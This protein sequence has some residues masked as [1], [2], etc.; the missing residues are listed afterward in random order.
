MLGLLALLFLLA[1]A[2]CACLVELNQVDRNEGRSKSDSLEWRLINVNGSISI[3]SATAGRSVHRDL[4]TAGIIP[5]P[6]VG[7]NEG[8]TRWVAEEP[9]WTYSTSLAHLEPLNGAQRTLLHF[10]WID[11]RASVI[12]SDSLGSSITVLEANNAHRRW[13]EDITAHLRIGQGPFT[14][15]IQLHSPITFAAQESKHEPP[16]PTQN[17]I[18]AAPA[19]QQYAYPH[20]N[21]IRMASHDFGW[22][23]GP[24]FADSGFGR[25]VLVQFGPCGEDAL[26]LQPISSDV[27]IVKSDD[28]LLIDTA[29]DV[30]RIGGHWRVNASLS[31][32][33]A[34]TDNIYDSEVHVTVEGT[35][36]RCNARLANDIKPG[37]NDDG[38]LWAICDI[39]TAAPTSRDLEWKV[40]LGFRSI[41][42]DQ[43]VYTADEVKKDGITP[44]SAFAFYINDHPIPLPIL[45]SNLIPFSTFTLSDR[46]EAE[47]IDYTMN[48]LIASEQN[49][50][51]I[52]GGGHYGSDRLYAKADELG[53]LIWSEFAFACSLYPTYPAFLKNVKVEAEEQV[54]RVS[55]YAS[56][57]LWAGNNEGELDMLPVY[58]TYANGSVYKQQ[59]EQLFNDLLRRVVR[60]HHPV[61]AYIASSTTTGGTYLEGSNY[62]FLP[63][64]R[65]FPPGE[66]HGDGE[67][68]NYNASQALDTS[69]YPRSRFVNEFG[70]HSM[71]DIRA[72]D[73]IVTRPED[74]DFNSTIVRSRSKH[75]PPGNL[76]YPW[77]ADDGQAQMTEGVAA[78]FPIPR[79]RS[80]HQRDTR[81]PSSSSG[82]VG[83]LGDRALLAQ[84]AYSTQCYQALYIGNQI[85]FYRL[86]T[87]GPER[88]TGSL[89]WQLNSIW[90]AATDWASLEVDG[91]WKILHYMVARMHDQVIAYVHHDSARRLI[92][93]HAI[94]R[95]WVQAAGHANVT[96]YDWNGH[97]IERQSHSFRINATASKKIAAFDLSVSS[98]RSKY[99]AKWLHVQL[100]ASLEGSKETF[101]NEQFFTPSSLGRVP[102][103][104]AKLILRAPRDDT[105]A[106]RSPSDTTQHPFTTRRSTEALEV[107]IANEGPGVAAWVVLT[108]S[109]R[110]KGWFVDAR[111]RGKP[112]NGFWLRPGENRSLRFQCHGGP[113][114]A[115]ASV[116]RDVSVTSMWDNIEARA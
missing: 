73:K 39:P 108:H 21:F 28:L 34:L 77:P 51:R 58:R 31:L 92:Q 89:Y 69:T 50:I 33:S 106:W 19:S 84:W 60:S 75:S 76:S 116:E 110:L 29:I 27:R 85:G 105:M 59:Y 23:W 109:A 63:R 102:L 81:K 99:E 98:S 96:W 11:T 55:R 17:D 87:D 66:I 5:D 18:P 32:F 35:D 26:R 22:D 4:L 13:T 72:F 78:Y 93:V 101:T 95:A 114:L 64:Y 70:M 57:S 3:P 79:S 82:K 83:A 14:L 107:E 46:E 54:R 53:I 43:H 115:G 37:M 65:N 12:L 36:V 94:S 6:E 25:A 97:V 90:K 68:Y 91:R 15:S 100:E 113:C 74:Y 103:Q 111:D 16:F 20:R 38:R 61:S 2:T 86:R 49:M 41:R 40:R 112:S 48:A 88:N 9:A 67:H 42:L 56:H 10:D 71:A 1:T 104:P 24:A 30:Q 62:S 80:H 8:T 45:G 7:L 52:W 44:G 47:V